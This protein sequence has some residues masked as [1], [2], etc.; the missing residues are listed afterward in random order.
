MK[1]LLLFFITAAAGLPLPGTVFLPASGCGML[2][3]TVPNATTW[4]MAS[5]SLSTIR[6]FQNDIWMNA[7]QLSGND[8]MYHVPFVA[9]TTGSF[10][11]ATNTGTIQIVDVIVE[12]S[13]EQEFVVVTFTITIVLLLIVIYVI[14]RMLVSA[15]FAVISAFD[16]LCCWKGETLFDKIKRH[17]TQELARK[18]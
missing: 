11:L 18:A 10:F 6:F 3:F 8:E 12:R 1:A 13:Q 5:G 7:I 9:E 2:N 14:V 16:Y 17:R 15:A 4:L